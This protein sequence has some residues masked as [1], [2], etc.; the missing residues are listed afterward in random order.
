[1]RLEAKGKGGAGPVEANRILT[2][3]LRDSRLVVG[4]ASFQQVWIARDPSVPVSELRDISTTSADRE[5]GR[6]RAIAA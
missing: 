6:V 4:R 2:L 3:D 1:M 5:S